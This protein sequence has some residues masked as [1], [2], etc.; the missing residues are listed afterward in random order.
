M[1]EYIFVVRDCDDMV[2]YEDESRVM[3]DVV[4]REYAEKYPQ[5]APYTV[6]FEKRTN[7]FDPRGE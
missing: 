6:H 2:A 1:S 3:A 7:E 4:S 5:F